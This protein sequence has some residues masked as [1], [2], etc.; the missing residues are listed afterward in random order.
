MKKKN[1]KNQHPLL[2]LFNIQ[3]LG[4]MEKWPN[5]VD[6]KETHLLYVRVFV[7]VTYQKNVFST[8]VER[9]CRDASTSNVRLFF[10]HLTETYYR[11]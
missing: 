5:I 8:E 7:C 4:D 2:H 1:D 11:I 10:Y 6:G 3:T 9:P